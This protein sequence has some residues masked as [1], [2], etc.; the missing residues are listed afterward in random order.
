[1]GCPDS[2]IPEPLLRM[3]QVNCSISDSRKQPYKDKLCFFRALA[4]HLRGSTNLETTTSMV[5]FLLFLKNWVVIRINFVECGNLIYHIGIEDGDFVGKLARKSIGNYE[6]VVKFLR[7]NSHNIYVNNIDNFFKC[8]RCP[9][10]NTFFNLSQNF[11]KHLLRCK[12]RIKNIYPKNFYTLR[13]TLFEK[14]DGFNIEYTKDQNLF[15]MSLF[16]T[17]NQFACH[18]KT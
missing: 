5:F 18:P 7:Y 15:K 4:V 10:C 17:L 9:T 1:M 6:N 11:N 13:E 12:H 8:F 16:L 3:Y 2:V 14:L